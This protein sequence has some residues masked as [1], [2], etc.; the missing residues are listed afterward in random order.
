MAKDNA[1]IEPDELENEAEFLSIEDSFDIE[2][3]FSELNNEAQNELQLLAEF[4]YVSQ[5]EL[6]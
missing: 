3:P 4:G 5:T 2:I 6:L 1:I